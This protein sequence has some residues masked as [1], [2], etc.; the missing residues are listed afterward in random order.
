M[1]NVA[2]ISPMCGNKLYLSIRT[3]HLLSGNGWLL[4]DNLSRIQWMENMPAP[5]SVLEMMVCECQKLA[6]QKYVS[7]L[8]FGARMH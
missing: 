4:R 1:L 8:S 2:T 7:L 6:L 5:E 3:Y